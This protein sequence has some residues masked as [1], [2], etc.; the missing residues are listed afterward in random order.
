MKSYSP[1]FLLIISWLG[2]LVSAADVQSSQLLQ[3]TNLNGTATFSW[4][5]AASNFVLQTTASPGT[6]NT[7]TDL[8]LQ[9]N[10][11]GNQIKASMVLTNSQQFFRLRTPA[12]SPF[13][14]LFSFA[15]F[16]N[17][18]LE[19][20]LGAGMLINGRVHSNQNIWA[21]GS[22]SGASMLN[23]SGLVDAVGT[24]E[25]NRSPLDPAYAPHAGYV[26]FKD[27]AV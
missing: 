9:T 21:T 6:S 1:G 11:V 22:G 24:I 16:Y 20:N 12:S 4:P 17:L 26:S 8:L 23:F 5:L 15:A 10:Q 7:W 19:I 18:D 3:I 2:L 14:P 13:I 25:T 27:I